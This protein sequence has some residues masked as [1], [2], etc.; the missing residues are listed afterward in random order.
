MINNR[1][2]EGDF[3]YDSTVVV[4]SLDDARRRLEKE[5][6][7]ALAYWEDLADERDACDP[8]DPLIDDCQLVRRAEYWRIEILG[9][10]FD[11][12]SYEEDADELEKLI[13]YG[14]ERKFV[15]TEEV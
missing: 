5:M 11:G 7:D 14:R 12:D 6:N 3:D 9:V 13:V 8:D 10:L 4:E 15:L 2:W 1:I